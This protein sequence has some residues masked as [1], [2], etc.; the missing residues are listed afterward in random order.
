MHHKQQRLTLITLLASLLL[1]GC[2]ALPLPINVHLTDST[3]V[4]RG[5]ALEQVIGGMEFANF[6]AL[7]ISQSQELQNLYVG[8]SAIKSA[9]VKILELSVL[10]PAEQNFDFIQEMSFFVEA[11]GQPAQRI[12][13]REVPRNARF[14]RFEI[15]EVDLT[16]YIM[17]ETMQ[18]TTKVKGRRPDHDTR[19]GSRLVIQVGLGVM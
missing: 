3:S 13:H 4:E 12:A 16:P 6:A 18:I 2:S 17:A 7:D 11:E 15:D 19:I 5:T 14:F 1:A 10:E 8:K 9:R